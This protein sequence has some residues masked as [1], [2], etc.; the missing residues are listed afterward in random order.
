MGRDAADRWAE[1]EWA[2]LSQEERDRQVTKAFERLALAKG[3]RFK[4]AEYQSAL[5]KMYS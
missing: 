4:K 2:V 5:E 3:R 1:E